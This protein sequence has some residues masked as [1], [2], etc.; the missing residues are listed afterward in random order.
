MLTQSQIIQ[1]MSVFP[2]ELV[3]A[4][5]ETSI[6]GLGTVVIKLRVPK[7]FSP[8]TDGYYWKSI[9]YTDLSAVWYTTP[10]DFTK[11]IALILCDRLAS[12]YQDLQGET[13]IP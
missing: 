7:T 13:I 9:Y 6:N 12:A 5:F 11:Q 2:K 8:S 10:E 4:E 1:A 3:K